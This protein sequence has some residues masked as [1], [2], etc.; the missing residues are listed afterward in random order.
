[1]MIAPFLA[2]VSITPVAGATAAPSG[3]ALYA[4]ALSDAAAS[5]GVHITGTI[6]SSSFVQHGVEDT[7]QRGGTVLETIAAG[8]AQFAFSERLIGSKLY[9]NGDQDSLETQLQL[10]QVTAGFDAGYWRV[11]PTTSKYYEELSYGLNLATSIDL[12]ALAPPFT[13]A[14]PL[15]HDNTEAYAI[16]S[17]TG[18][19]A[20]SGLGPG[21]GAFT[22]WV[23][24]G[25]DPLP[26]AEVGHDVVDNTA[27]VIWTY[28]SHWG[29]RFVV[30]APKIV[31][32]V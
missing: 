16:S 20:G 1:M 10:D 17:A 30:G 27:Q 23:S 3:T 32:P 21:R 6:T 7:D 5:S 28:F 9:L 25:R 18:L 8:S 12:I 26:I 2:G 19:H 14:G 31:K 29:E 15:R 4:K 13:V 22:L 24:T 11:V